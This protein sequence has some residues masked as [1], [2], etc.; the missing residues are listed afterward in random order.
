MD[1]SIFSEMV[2]AAGAAEPDDEEVPPDTAN[3]A[4]ASATSATPTKGSRS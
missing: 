4:P 1:K 3:A 2:G